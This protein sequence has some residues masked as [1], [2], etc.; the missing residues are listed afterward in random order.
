M[1]STKKTIAAPA[2]EVEPDWLKP[3][4]LKYDIAL[5]AK[6]WRKVH[7]PHLAAALAA[8]EAAIRATLEGVSPHAYSVAEILSS[9]RYSTLMWE[10]GWDD[11]SEA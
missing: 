10:S 5:N 9:A 2:V 4:E 8:G 3:V 6:A 11:E 1:K 7:P